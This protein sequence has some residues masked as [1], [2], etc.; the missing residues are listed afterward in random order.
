MTYGQ[1]K[2]KLIGL[3]ASLVG[4][5]RAR[6]VRRA[7]EMLSAVQEAGAMD[8]WCDEIERLPIGIDY[9]LELDKFL[10]RM[11]VSRK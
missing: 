5:N 6:R 9:I 11:N 10:D 1:A 7:A 8:L 4:E 2:T 3:A